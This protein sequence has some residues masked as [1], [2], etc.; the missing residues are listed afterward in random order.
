MEFKR[1][2]RLRNLTAVYQP[3]G[4]LAHLQCNR[5]GITWSPCLQSGGKLPRRYWQC[6]NDCNL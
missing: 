2:L 3:N 6:P 5:C 4:A 1:V